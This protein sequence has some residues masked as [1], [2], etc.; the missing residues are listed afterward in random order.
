MICLYCSLY[1]IYGTDELLQINIMLQ[2]KLEN[3]ID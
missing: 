3:W 1:P 2:I